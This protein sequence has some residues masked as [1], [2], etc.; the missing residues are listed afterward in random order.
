MK[1]KR[2]P[3]SATSSS[4]SQQEGKEPTN[5][6]NVNHFVLC[7][8]EEADAE[9]W[10]LA[11]ADWERLELERVTGGRKGGLKRPKPLRVP[12]VDTVWR[13]EAAAEARCCLVFRRDSANFS[14][15]SFFF[16]LSLVEGR[17]GGARWDRG[18][19]TKSGSKAKGVFCRRMPS[20][21]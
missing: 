17:G 3:G 4:S 21:V 18:S 10:L 12:I 5:D 15:F 19:N 7:V 13:V 20:A 1:L 6:P 2:E 8:P 9:G 11:L 16:V 14:S